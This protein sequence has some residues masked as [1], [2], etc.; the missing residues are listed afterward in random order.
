MRGPAFR[1]VP[2][3]F[4]LSLVFE[5]KPPPQLKKIKGQVTHVPCQDNTVNYDE[6]FYSC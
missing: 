4:P 5:V 3:D 6:G 2:G 1:L